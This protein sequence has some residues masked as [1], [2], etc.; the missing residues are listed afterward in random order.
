MAY[1]GEDGGTGPWAVSSAGGGGMC[2]PTSAMSKVQPW[3]VAARFRKQLDA[4][5][6]AAPVPSIS[7][8]KKAINSCSA[9]FVV[10]S[11]RCIRSVQ[12]QNRE[13]HSQFRGG[14]RNLA[15]FQ[16][17]RSVVLSSL[18]LMKAAPMT[19]TSPGRTRSI[20]HN[21]W[22]VRWT[23]TLRFGTSSTGWKRQGSRLCTPPMEGTGTWLPLANR[24]SLVS[25]ILMD[26]D[27]TMN[28]IITC[29]R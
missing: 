13:G 14:P 1:P 25:V 16:L 17:A 20:V 11:A 7:P 19:L 23:C 22:V 5:E 26:Y 28:T 21:T 4:A 9:N 15:L 29:V 6:E 27:A 18:F 8:Q 2:V 3:L 24:T 10:S 12:G